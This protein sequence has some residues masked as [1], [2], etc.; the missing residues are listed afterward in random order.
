MTTT[1]YKRKFGKKPG[2]KVYIDGPFVSDN[3][4]TKKENE[5]K[6][7]QE[8]YQSMKIR[9]EN[10]TYEYIKYKGEKE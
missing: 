2:I 10:S 5:E 9:S 7:C 8:I 6:I 1:Y 4:L 3:K